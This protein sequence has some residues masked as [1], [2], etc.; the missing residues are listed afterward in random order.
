MWKWL[1]PYAKHETQYH[2][3]GKLSPFLVIAVL[4]LAVGIVW[5]FSL[6]SGRLSARQ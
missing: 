4:L 1:H 6:C 3:C 2:L 5:G